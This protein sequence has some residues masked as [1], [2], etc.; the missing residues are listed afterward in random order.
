MRSRMKTIRLGACRI[1]WGIFRLEAPGLAEPGLVSPE[2]E[3]VLLMEISSPAAMDQFLS[4][5]LLRGN[6]VRD[7]HELRI[8]LRPGETWSG[9]FRLCRGT[10]GPGASSRLVCRLMLDGREI[11]RLEVLLG[12]P[13][14]DAQG[15]FQDPGQPK[16]SDATLLAY[17]QELQRRLGN[18]G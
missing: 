1:R 8:Q 2:L 15:R 12:K 11:D 17:Q 14:V 7:R 3:L 9:A 4:F 16:P 10:G 18:S 5:E 13:A 6:Q